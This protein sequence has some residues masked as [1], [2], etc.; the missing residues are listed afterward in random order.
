M[1][2]QTTT[3]NP[4][5]KNNNKKTK[6][7]KQKKPHTHTQKNNSNKNEFSV[8]HSVKSYAFVLGYYVSAL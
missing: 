2:K 6:Q 7:K 3:H 4:L 8:E 5:P 1:T